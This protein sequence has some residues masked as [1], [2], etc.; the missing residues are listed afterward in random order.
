MILHHI[1]TSPCDNAL[2]TCLK[3][4]KKDDAIIFSSDGVNIVLYQ[5]HIDELIDYKIFFLAD[6]VKARGLIAQSAAYS[7]IDYQQFVELTL[8]FNKV[9]TW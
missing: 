2:K 7:L 9:I 1:Q 5:S 4:I 3:Y 6:D 8:D